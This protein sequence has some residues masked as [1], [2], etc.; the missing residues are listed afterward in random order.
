MYLRSCQFPTTFEGCHWPTSHPQLAWWND[1]RFCYPGFESA[2]IVTAKSDFPGKEEEAHPTALP[3]CGCLAL[4]DLRRSG[5]NSL[6]CRGTAVACAAEQVVASILASFT[7]RAVLEVR[8]PPTWRD[9]HSAQRC[10]DLWRPILPRMPA[11]K[12]KQPQLT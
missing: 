2:R 1:G 12:R 3:G 11:G 7:V 5:G 6:V 9:K 8:I 10:L 4:H